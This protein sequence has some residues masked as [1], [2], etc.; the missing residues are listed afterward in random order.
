MGHNAGTKYFGETIVSTTLQMSALVVG[1]SMVGA[2]LALGLA[3]QGKKVAVLEPNF[4]TE[5]H[6]DNRFDLR[7]SAVTADNIKFL[8]QL[9]AWARIESCRANPFFQLSV[10]DRT[11]QWLDIGNA[12]SPTPLGYMIENEVLQYALYQ[13][14]AAHKL[15]T[16]IPGK[17]AE[18][19]AENGIARL[20]D[21]VIEEV[22]FDFVFGCDGSQSRV[23]SA[24]GIGTTGRSYNHACLLCNVKTKQSIPPATWEKFNRHE[25]HALL[26][27]DDQ[28]ACLIVYADRKDISHWQEQHLLQEVL[29][30][31]FN[32]RVGPFEIQ[33]SGSFPL[34]RQSALRYQIWSS[35][36]GIRAALFG[37][38]A[39]TIHPLAGQGVNLGFR[40]VAQFLSL[41][42]KHDLSAK[43]F[44]R[45]EQLR[46]LDNEIMAHAME[47]IGW[48]M[49]SEGA[50]VRSLRSV[51]IQALQKLPK[52]KDALALY[53]S[54]TWK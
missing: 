35:A 18:L 43:T 32:E 52:A 51:A 13:E 16:L 9:Q 30:E 37:D 20:S 31:R 5:W 28:H 44:A 12:A 36:T 33:S 4:T 39:H 45:Y 8:D 7:I 11:E 47:A 50:F 40:D 46:K 3:Q 2:A 22:Q 17:L 10:C 29:S 42:A 19:D 21:S 48:G 54:R 24:L 6:A 34:Q 23:R 26:P 53:A 38:A 41:V 14:M 27:L 25:I 49:R 15:I 1:G